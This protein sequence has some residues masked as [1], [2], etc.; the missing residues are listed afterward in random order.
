[1]SNKMDIKQIATIVL[2]AGLSRRMGAPKMVLPWG[3]TT[4]IGQVV[5]VLSQAGLGEILV[6]TGGARSQ[7]EAALRGSLA[8]TV[9]NPRYQ[10]DRMILSLQLGLA[11]LSSGI[12]AALVALGDQPQI[13]GEVVAAIL[14]AYFA[15]GAPLVVPSFQMRR[16]HPWLVDRSLWG[17]IMALQPPQTLRNLMNAHQ[18]QIAYLNV[19]DDTILRDLDTPEDYIREHPDPVT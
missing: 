10:E 14:S 1:M 13:K 3:N 7:V 5:N 16:G 17:E 18:D 15:S 4:V 9:F 11:G 19:L 8:R 2:A 6:V 12:Q